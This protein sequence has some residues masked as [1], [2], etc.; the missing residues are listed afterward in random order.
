[1][2]EIPEHYALITGATSGIGYEIAK[3]FAED[4]YNL[5]IVG[6]FTETL[7][8]TAT[9]FT[10][11]GVRVIPIVADL[12]FPEQAIRVHETVKAQ[13]IL[14]NALVN[15]AGQA[16][17]GFFAATD[18]EKDLY[19]IQLNISSLVVLT[20]LFLRDMLGRNMGRILLLG[21]IGSIYPAPLQAVYGGTKAFIL[22]FGE[23]LA[24]ELKDTDVTITT[25]LPGPTDTDFFNKAGAQ[26]SRM[27]QDVP[28]SDPAEVAKD[29]YKAMMKGE[30]KI[31][32]GVKNKIMAGLSNVLPDST[33]A[34]IMRA[35]S[36]TSK[37]DV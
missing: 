10:H 2:Q 1:M 17:H 18:L 6:R 3:L 14:V 25:L 9:K 23:A 11:Y 24:N 19:D 22:S 35:Q 12:A 7:E 32:S 27:A 4:G 30:T 28:Q 15:D 26:A 36:N 21:S 13:N 16:N 20:K 37:D 33:Q 29:G 34:A 5:I 8:E 31:M